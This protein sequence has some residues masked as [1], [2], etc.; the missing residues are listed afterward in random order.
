MHKPL[1][2]MIAIFF[3]ICLLTCIIPI[4]VSA[5]TAADST[6]QPNYFIEYSNGWGSAVVNVPSIGNI[7][8]MAV[9]ATHQAKSSTIDNYEVLALS[10]SS[11]MA[12]GSAAAAITTN[13][14]SED[15][16]WRKALRNGS[17]TY[18][19]INGIVTIPNILQVTANELRVVRTGN[20]VTVDFEPRTPVVVTLPRDVFPAANFS[21]AWAVPAFHL[22][23]DV[24][25]SVALGNSTTAA[26]S[27][28]I[29]YNEYTTANANFTFTCSSWSNYRASGTGSIRTFNVHRGT[30]P[31]GATASPDALKSLSLYNFAQG[32]FDIPKTGGITRLQIN[33]LHAVGSE[34]TA[35]LDIIQVT[36][37][38]AGFSGSVLAGISTAS[39]SQFVR[40]LNNGSSTYTEVNGNVIINNI[41]SV[42]PDEL[43]VQCNGTRLTVTFNPKTPL[44]I[45]LPADGFPRTNFSA[46][47]TLPALNLT[48]IANT[49]IPYLY[50]NN[51]VSFASGWKQTNDFVLNFAGARLTVPTWNLTAD[52]GGTT[53]Y[54]FPYMVTTYISPLLPKQ[55]TATAF[56]NVRV[57]PGWTWYF[58]AHSNEGVAPYTYQWYEGTNLLQGQTSMIL[59]MSK[60]APGTYSFYCKVIDAQGITA[61]SNAVTLTIIG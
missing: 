15:I 43:K 52:I 7:T 26:P 33:A 39:D 4:S 38:A 1:K 24:N 58:F 13:F 45:M 22:D 23:L 53:T 16:S 12:N 51:A 18:T 11:S 50:L 14:D 6:G 17:A 30:A 49:T 41:F 3:L 29:E 48:F 57:L 34:S 42:S 36:P 44:N 59:P 25:G 9:V 27:G 60:T 32:T 2:T 40:A 54:L 56:T 21:A 8:R 35:P 55:P 37:T 46:T 5:S 10:L 47:W 19:E 61:N 31:G 28:W 20:R